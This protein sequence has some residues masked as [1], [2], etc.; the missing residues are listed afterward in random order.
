VVNR[1]RHWHAHKRQSIAR[2]SSDA[3]F[4]AAQFASF[5]PVGS[6]DGAAWSR[7]PQQL[8]KG[9]LLRRRRGRDVLV[10]QRSRIGLRQ[11][12]C[13]SRSHDDLLFASKGAGQR[14]GVAG[15][16]LPVLPAALAV[17]LHLAA[18]DGLLR[19]GSRLEQAGDVEP[20]IEADRGVT[21]RH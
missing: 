15:A 8:Q 7:V 17:D 20:D 6:V 5:A 9:Q 12:L 19:G 16:H 1:E 3:P 18:L 10:Q 4:H 13:G 14:Q 2:R 11:V 21:H